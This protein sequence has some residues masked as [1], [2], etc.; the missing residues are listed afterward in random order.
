LLGDIADT[1]SKSTE[2]EIF[3]E[4]YTDA[5][6]DSKHNTKLS[7]LRATTIKNYF[8]GKG[9][10]P[11]KIHASGMGS[12]NPLGSNQTAAG[13]RINRRVEIKLKHSIH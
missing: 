9:I 12:R 5:A 11:S 13:R 7:E 10:H 2:V 6:G 3:I 8:I 1:A 4:G